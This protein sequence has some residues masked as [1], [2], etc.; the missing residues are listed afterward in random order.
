MTETAFVR[1]GVTVCSHCN[2]KHQLGLTALEFCSRCRRVI[3]RNETA[4]LREGRVVCEA[5]DQSLAAG[6]EAVTQTPTA[7][8]LD[9]QTPEE[10]EPRET[11]SAEWAT[12]V[13]AERQKHDEESEQ[14]DAARQRAA[15]ERDGL[16]ATRADIERQAASLDSARQRAAAER[17]GLDATRAEIERREAAFEEAKRRSEMER[18][19]APA[20]AIPPP[21]RADA[22]RLEAAAAELQAVESQLAAQLGQLARYQAQLAQREEAMAK[23]WSTHRAAAV[24]AAAFVAAVALAVFCYAA[25]QRVVDPVWRASASLEVKAL[26]DADPVSRLAWLDA[27]RDLLLSGPV[28]E[29]TI[30][31]LGERGV[32]LDGKAAE[33]R[34]HLGSELKARIDASN[35]LVLELTQRRPESA[36]NEVYFQLDALSRAYLGHLQTQND[37]AEPIAAT[38]I[39]EVATLERSPVED[40]RLAVGAAIFLAAL[41]AAALAVAGVRWWM[42]RSTP[43]AA[44]PLAGDTPSA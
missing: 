2:L 21:R 12:A 32:A 1:A 19:A 14:L 42:I 15:A 10:Q 28:L 30:H 38:G 26:A 34:D 13:Q 36:R 22:S 9:A 24:V 20:G 29:E 11:Q 3:R 6:E 35:R 33:L 7:N 8:T 18:N 37:A 25:G 43:P 41:G 44:L 4:H 16:E 17:A 27:Q 31:R 39:S 5:C 23:R 40:R